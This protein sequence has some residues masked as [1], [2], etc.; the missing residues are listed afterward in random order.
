MKKIGLCLVIVAF[1]QT[2]YSNAQTLTIANV[3][4][5]NTARVPIP[6]GPAVYGVFDGRSP[7]QEIAKEIHVETIPECTK[8]KWR[9]ILF[10]DSATHQPT[11]YQLE[12]FVFRHPVK[13]GKWAAVRGT[14]NDPDALVFELDPDKAEGFM[15]LMK[16]DDNVLFLLDR[17][18][19]LM[20]GNENF[21]YIL[22]RTEN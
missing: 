21:S 6:T 10:Q 17:N 7:C 13:T 15:F 3:P 22:Y 4:A 19:Q 1:F 9:L 14:K 16:A 2:G 18:R 11:Y 12:G 5:K 8:I 20:V